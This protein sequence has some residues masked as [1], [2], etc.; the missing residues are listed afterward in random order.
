MPG[1]VRL[2]DR[3]AAIYAMAKLDPYAPLPNLRLFQMTENIIDQHERSATPVSLLELLDEHQPG[4]IVQTPSYMSN[5][6]AWGGWDDPT[7]P[8]EEQWARQEAEEEELLVSQHVQ[9]D[10]REPG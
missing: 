9:I 4:E 6:K 3:M 1:I 2:C 7:D 8:E 10:I 5:C